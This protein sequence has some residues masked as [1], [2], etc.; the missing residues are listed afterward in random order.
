M[1]KPLF[2]DPAQQEQFERLGYVCVPFLSEEEVASLTAYFHEHITEIPEGFCSTSYFPGFDKKKM[3]SDH[4]GQAFNP[5]FSEILQNYM[6]FGGAFLYKTAS[7]HSELP[8]HQDWTIV[9]EQEFVAV[10]VW[11]PLVDTTVENGTLHVFPG[12]H[13][14]HTLRAPT[15][16]FF[17]NGN[18][19]LVAQ[20]LIPMPTKA[21][22][23]II[24]NQNLIHFSPP[25]QTDELRLAITCGVKS[26]DAPMSFYYKD[27]E[28]PEKPI[29]VF[30]MD[31]DF[32]LRFENFMV[33]IMRRP[34]FGESR[35]TIDFEVEILEREALAKEI[36]RLKMD[37]GIAVEEEVETAAAA[38]E[39][40]TEIAFPEL[41]ED[42]Q[43]KGLF[44]KIKKALW[45]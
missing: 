26:D 45:G 4:I 43:P 33:D 10:N 15:L 6:T 12:S 14:Y 1:I 32:L 5:H 22:H 38:A 3:I 18:E 31:D 44:Q 42:Q 19:D 25:N 30:S 8:I 17:Y 20:E 28:N 9:D 29:E 7:P 40:E 37:A 39:S 36:R 34:D 11:C 16:P 41:P 27:K 24:L 2:K 23:A 13:K 21:G 35:G